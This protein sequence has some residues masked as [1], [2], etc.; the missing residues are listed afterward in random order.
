MVT[1]MDRQTSTF[2]QMGGEGVPWIG[3]APFTEEKHIF[4]NL[5]DGTYVHSGLLAVRQAL[6]ANVPITY[7]ILYNDAVAMTGGQPVE[8]QLSVSR[9]TRQLEAE[10]VKKI[11]IVTSDPEKYQGITDL[12]H[13]VPVFHR[14]ELDKVQRELR[15]YPGV[16]VL[17]YDQVC[18]TEAR[19]RRKR[20]KMPRLTQRVVINEA[21]C[22]GCGDCSVQSNCLSVIPIETDFGTKRQIDQSACNQ[23]FSCLKGFCPSFITL[24]GANPRKGTATVDTQFWGDLPPPTYPDTQTPYN[25]IITGVGGMGVITLGALV[26]MAAHLDGK[27]VSTLDMTG[28]AQKYGAVFSHLR[29]ADHPEDIHAAR[30]ATG[31]AHA[32]LG[33]DLV[34]S[35]SPEALSKMLE[36]KTRAV[37]SCT[38]TPTAEFTRNPLWQFPLPGLQ[39]QLTD[40]L[41]KD[42]VQFIDAQHLATRLMGNALYANMLLLGLAWQRGL[43]PVSLDALNK[44]IE[45]NGTDIEANRQALLW[46]RRA[47]VFPSQVAAIAGPLGGAPHEAM[48]L[49]ALIEHRAAYLTTYQDQ[50]LA[51]RYRQRVA[52]IQALGD[53]TLTRNVA[54]QYARLL[55]PKDEYEVARLHTD[56]AFLDKLKTEFEGEAKI[57]FHL[58]PP[59]FAKPGPNGRPRKIRFGPWLLPILKGLARCRHLRGTWLDPFRFAPDKATDRQLLAHYE[60]DIDLILAH[61]EQ[62]GA[63]RELAKWPATVPGFGP[64]REYAAKEASKER[65]KIR[66]AFQ[67]T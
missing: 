32:I 61:P 33:G 18:A 50:R 12:A 8:G 49:T 38:E 26:G 30:I 48:S 10:G 41:G 13:G 14:D 37:I 46:G 58:A 66:E 35:A 24:D 22:E 5:G 60:A 55:A 54:T 27:G 45:L 19:R 20:G 6:A 23:D 67:L 40:I 7:K 11:V 4:A 2:T 17:I 62:L 21:V 15:Q 34:V 43:V 1:W 53:D 56:S 25:L 57:S 51:E 16:S 28:L 47:A 39:R 65:E 64:V 52:S 59:L 44:A 42:R 31:E 29:I 9:M 63:A 36:G 3:Q